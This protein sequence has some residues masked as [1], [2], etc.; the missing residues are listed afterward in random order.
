MKRFIASVLLAFSMFFVAPGGAVFAS[1]FQDKF[2]ELKSQ[3]NN[4]EQAINSGYYSDEQKAEALKNLEKIDGGIAEIEK[5]YEANPDVESL[6]LDVVNNVMKDLDEDF[7]ELKAS[8]NS[9]LNRSSLG[10]LPAT[11]KSTEQC[12]VL[13]NAISRNPA[14][15][16]SMMREQDRLVFFDIGGYQTTTNDILACAIKTG[17]I[18]LWMVP[19]YIKFFL[20]FVID[21]A[22]LIAVGGLVYAGYVYLFSGL[23]D[24]KEKGKK[25]IMYS[26]A[27]YIMTL[28]AWAF[29]NLI[30][31][32]LT[33]L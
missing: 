19:Y 10:L 12:R 3:R 14:Q 4:Y 2:A 32:L 25:A 16:R 33:G 20:E 24:G 23:S 5:Q 22:G 21:V 26:I 1:E 9:S 17:D 30:L 13:M 6:H 8:A 29:V 27:G 15:T 7:N 31:S 18:N 28:L 11:S